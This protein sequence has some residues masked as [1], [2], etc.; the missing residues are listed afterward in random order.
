MDERNVNE[1]ETERREVCYAHECEAYAVVVRCA[2]GVDTLRCE[3]CGREWRVP[4]GV[5]RVEQEM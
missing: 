1:A 5:G 3:R 4:C 2:D